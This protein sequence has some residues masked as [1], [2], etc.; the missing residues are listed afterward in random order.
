MRIWSEDFENEEK[1]PPEF[2]ADGRDTNPHLA[3]D[4]V[5]PNARSLAL[6][7]DDPD[8]PKGTFTHW[9]VSNLPPK[10]GQI[11]H[12]HVPGNAKMAKNDFG[13]TDYGGPSPPSGTHRYFFKLYALDTEDINASEKKEF[14][15]QV[16]KHSI[17]STQLMGQYS[18]S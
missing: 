10:P 16:K 4:N 17:D 12:G 8:A 9:L 13:K 2:T 15:Q 11:D 14:Y 7:M 3:W 5:P 18:R 1:I 6:I